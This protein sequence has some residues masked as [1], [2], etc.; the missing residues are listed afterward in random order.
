MTVILLA[1][2]FYRSAIGAYRA[3]EEEACKQNLD[4]IVKKL[5]A[6]AIPRAKTLG[7]MDGLLK[8][9]IDKNTGKILGCMLLHPIPVKLSIRL[10]LP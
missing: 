4:I 10:P 2:L 7:E 5:P 1:T 3:N 9:I 6:M 8:A